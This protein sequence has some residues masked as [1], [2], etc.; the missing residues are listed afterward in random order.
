LEFSITMMKT[1]LIGPVAR[2]AMSPGAGGWARSR[3]YK[4]TP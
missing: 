4:S 2:C 1:L 3:P